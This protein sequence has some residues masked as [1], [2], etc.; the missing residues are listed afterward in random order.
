[1]AAQIAVGTVDQAMLGALKVKHAY[2]RA[3]GLARSLLV[4]DEVHASDRFMTAIQKRLLDAHLSIGGYAML[5]SATLGSTA[6]AEW[7]DQKQPGFE[8]A[9]AAP[10]PAVW[11]SNGRAPRTPDEP[12]ALE[13]QRDGE[14]L[15][16]ARHVVLHDHDPAREPCSSRS[17]SKC[18]WT[19]GAA[20]ADPCQPPGS[21]QSRR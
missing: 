16:P 13:G 1:L 19:Y 5:M 11:T 7:L 9:V 12:P 8:E 3:A 14:R 10:Y 2:T 21:H 20:S 15:P 4:I 6:R 17:R 18:A